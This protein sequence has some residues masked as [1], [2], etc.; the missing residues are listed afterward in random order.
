MVKL[1]DTSDL[2]SD[3]VRCAGSSPVIRTIQ[4]VRLFGLF[5]LLSPIPI[6]VPGNETQNVYFMCM[7][8]YRIAAGL[9][10]AILLI[11][12]IAHYLTPERASSGTNRNSHLALQLDTRR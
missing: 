1:A 8:T 2:G 9:P 7:P 3:A 11:N 6:L 4:K 10:A 5:L 12:I